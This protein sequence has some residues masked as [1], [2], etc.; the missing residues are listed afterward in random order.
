MMRNHA[1]LSVDWRHLLHPILRAYP[2]LVC[3]FLATACDAT[4]Q[5][6]L[7]QG[8]ADDVIVALHA[9]GIGA[10]KET[11][12][13]GDDIRVDVH[14]APADIAPALEVLNNRSLPRTAPGGYEEIFGTPGL[15]PTATEEQ[16]RYV[17][18][19][20]GELSRS[21]SAIDG[22]ITARVHVALPENSRLRLDEEKPSPRA[23]VLIKYDGSS[24]PYDEAAVRALVAGAIQDMDPAAVAVVGVPSENTAATPHSL[25]HLGPV[26][27]TRGSSGLLKAILG[28][29]F[30]LHLVLAALLV[31]L[32][33]RRRRTPEEESS[34]AA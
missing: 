19:L 4:L 30:G 26:S 8:Q 25:V 29:A 2:I 18:A 20:S 5:S 3:V 1:R 32:L 17:A 27:V 13:T 31:A 33:V 21:I 23:S 16:A 24:A 34:D 14:V 11:R 12:G 10:W 15:V 6:G 9:A 7:P 28:G 22:V